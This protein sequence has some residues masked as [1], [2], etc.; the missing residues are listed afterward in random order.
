MYVLCGSKGCDLRAVKWS[1]D[2]VSRS[3]KWCEMKVWDSGIVQ[4]M[5]EVQ[6]R[7]KV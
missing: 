4:S 6:S 5:S 3:A 7:V 2:V 1:P